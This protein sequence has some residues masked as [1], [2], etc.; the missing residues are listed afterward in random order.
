MTEKLEGYELLKIDGVKKKQEVYLEKPLM[1]FLGSNKASK[2]VLHGLIHLDDVLFLLE[3]CEA[4]IRQGRNGI[5]VI[6]VASV[7]KEMSE[8]GLHEDN[9]AHLNNIVHG[10]YRNEPDFLQGRI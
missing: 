2:A 8:M 4:S 10:I 9:Y 7:P 1:V 3:D 5:P 6:S